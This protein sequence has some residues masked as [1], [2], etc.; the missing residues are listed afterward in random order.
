LARICDSVVPNGQSE[1][2][3][4]RGH[5]PL[6]IWIVDISGA[7]FVFCAIFFSS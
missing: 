5:L 3:R 1:V 6:A 4:G 2:V 7:G